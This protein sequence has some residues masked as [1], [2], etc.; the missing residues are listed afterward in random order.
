MDRLGR[1]KLHSDFAGGTRSFTATP[2]TRK[3]S[4]STQ[5]VVIAHTHITSTTH[6]QYSQTQ[7][8]TENQNETSQ[9][10][11]RHTQKKTVDLLL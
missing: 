1:L 6:S 10:D 4:V 11:N 3:S 8:D 7:R 9:L 2:D 5:A